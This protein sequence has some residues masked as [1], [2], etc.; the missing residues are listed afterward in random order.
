MGGGESGKE[1]G[2]PGKTAAGLGRAIGVTG[3]WQRAEEVSSG[4]QTTP[5]RVGSH[6]GS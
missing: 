2:A 4:A 5:W 6:A 3:G 1:R